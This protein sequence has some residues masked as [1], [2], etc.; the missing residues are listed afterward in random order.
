MLNMIVQMRNLG[1]WLF[2]VF[3]ISCFIFSIVTDN[4]Q[5]KWRTSWRACDVCWCWMLKHPRQEKFW[6]CNWLVTRPCSKCCLLLLSFLRK[7]AINTSFCLIFQDYAHVFFFPHLCVL[8][9][10][11]KYLLYHVKQYSLAFDTNLV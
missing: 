7:T 6:I 4:Q 2:L 11:K 10:L 9:L 3:D 8:D 1:Y 5:E